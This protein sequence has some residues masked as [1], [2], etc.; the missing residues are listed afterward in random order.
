MN[1]IKNI[2]LVEHLSC[3]KSPTVLGPYSIATKVNL[4]SVSMIFVSGT[5]GI[6]PL[7][8]EFISDDVEGQANQCLENIKQVLLENNSSLENVSKV[9]CFLVDMNDMKVFNEIYEKFFVSNFPARTTVA[10]KTLPRNAKI[11]I[12][13][14]A[15]SK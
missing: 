13:C 12:E 6:N 8:N 9:N 5:V 14:I 1:D 2:S 10:V 4:G 3:S 11:E 7:T 15:F